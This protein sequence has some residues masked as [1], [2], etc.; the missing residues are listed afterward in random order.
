MNRLQREIYE[1]MPW[2]GCREIVFT[3]PPY[4]E[5]ER[6]KKIP[7]ADR[8]PKYSEFYELQTYIHLIGGVKPG[9][10][11]DVG[12]GCGSLS[13]IFSHL[14]WNVI[15]CDI[16]PDAFLFQDGK[17]YKVDLNGGL[18]FKDMS[19][20][21]VVC[22][23]VIE[24]LNDPRH[25][26]S[27]FSR[28][29]KD[30]GSI[31]L[32]LPNIVSLNSRFKFLRDGYLSYFEGYWQDHRTIL[33]YEQLSSILQEYRFREIEFSTNRYEMFNL[34]PKVNGKRMRFLVPLLKFV[35]HKNMP[36]CCRFGQYIIISA[37]KGVNV[38][39]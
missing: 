15:S 36:E 5:I 26:I 34:N 33:H 35:S 39:T 3:K 30:G 9:F 11:C 37:K 18:P 6:L 27:E 2:S 4:E 24:H 12:A 10:M 1:A 25:L 29:L 13:Y 31:V 32:S 20:H 17:F 38:A 19:F 8:E 23:Q 22:K 14:G 7:L 16:D 28:I 21:C